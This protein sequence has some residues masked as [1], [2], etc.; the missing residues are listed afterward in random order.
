MPSRTLSRLAL[1]SLAAMLA[2]CGGG[3]DSSPDNKSSSGGG[4]TGGSARFEAPFAASAPMRYV[5]FGDGTNA[6][7]GTNERKPTQETGGGLR[8][9]AAYK[10]GSDTKIEDIAGNASYAKGTWVG[11]SLIR[12]GDN[13]AE[14]STTLSKPLHYAIANVPTTLA[15]SSA[16]KCSPVL[17]PARADG[18]KADVTGSATLSIAGGVAKAEIS[19]TV[20]TIPVK[21]SRDI[22]ANETN[23][24]QSALFSSGSGAELYLGGDAKAGYVLI[25]P[26]KA[27]S[28]ATTYRGVALFTCK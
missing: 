1:A 6:I 19:L 12:I 13:D 20:G 21:A 8:S 17:D 28:G 27:V 9:L 15:D 3:D 14:T 22:P 7:G 4:T 16:L 26:F 2:A 25:S 23:T 18:A 24:V 10:A 11:G 5:L